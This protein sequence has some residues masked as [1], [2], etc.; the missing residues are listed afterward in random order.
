VLH[1][2]IDRDGGVVRADPVSGPPELAKE[3]VDAVRQW[4]FKPTLLN[5]DPVEVDSTVSIV[6]S[7]PD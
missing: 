1:I 4:L 3:S 2:V 5:G 6:F 7:N